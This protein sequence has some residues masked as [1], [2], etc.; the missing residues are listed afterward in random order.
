MSFL[1]A[2]TN[3]GEI[4]ELNMRLKPGAQTLGVTLSD[5]SRQVRQSYYG[6]G[7]TPTSP[8]R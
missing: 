4:D 1:F 8:V 7:S 6:E 5:V 2:T 3:I